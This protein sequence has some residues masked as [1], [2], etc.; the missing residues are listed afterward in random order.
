MTSPWIQTSFIFLWCFNFDSLILITFN[1]VN[2]NSLGFLSSASGKEPACQ[3][4]RFKRHRFNPWLRISY[5]NPL[6]YSCLENPMDRIPWTWQATAH[7]V[8]KSWTRLKQLSTHTQFPRV[9]SEH[10]FCVLFIFQSLH[11]SEYRISL[12]KQDGPSNPTSI[13]LPL[14]PPPFLSYLHKIFS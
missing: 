7:G 10:T 14:L 13:K 9:R 5:G 3:C 2:Y 12:R 4:R 11:I 1:E 8:I 6:Q